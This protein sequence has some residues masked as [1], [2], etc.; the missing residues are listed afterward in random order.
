MQAVIPS[1]V[2][3]DVSGLKNLADCFVH[4]T[5]INTTFYI[6]DKHRTTI[7]WAGPVNVN[8]YDAEANPLN[9]RNQTVYDFQN[10][11]AYVYNA[12]GEYKEIDLSGQSTGTQGPLL[13]SLSGLEYDSV[14]SDSSVY[15]YTV[16]A[17]DNPEGLTF[18]QI[19]EAV[20]SGRVVRIT[21]IPTLCSAQTHQPVEGVTASDQISAVADFTHNLGAGFPTATKVITLSSGATLNNIFWGMFALFGEDNELQ[22]V[23]LQLAPQIEG[24]E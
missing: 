21:N 5:S 15:A 11:K 23:I 8:D 2:V 10:E 7:T 14:L 24:G 19:V 1:V 17:F 18:E 13:V 12:T 22:R 16:G 3:D 20:E 9:L 6:D 4:V